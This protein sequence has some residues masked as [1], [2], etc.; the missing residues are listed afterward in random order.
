MRRHHVLVDPSERRSRL[1]S[2]AAELVADTGMVVHE[3]PDLVD[4]HVELVEMP[5]LLRGELDPRFLE[6]PPEVVVVTLRHHQKCL[7]LESGEPVEAGS[8]PALAPGFLAVIDREDDPEGLIRQG[9]E[10]VIGARLADARFFFEEDRKRRMA[11]LVPSLARLDHHRRLGSIGHKAERIGALAEGLARRLSL[12]LDPQT[13]RR[14]A[15]LVKADLL[16]NMV[17]ELPELQGVMGGHYLRLEGEPEA[18]WTAA[19][20]HYRP[21]GFDG[22]LPS[23]E[24]GRVLGVADRLDTVAGL[25]AAGE[26][27][28]GSK[29][30]FG[31]RRAA[32]G[33]VRI[34]AES[35]WELDL[36][37]ALDDAVRQV[38][39]LLSGDGGPDLAELRTSLSTFVAERVRRYLVELAGA[40]PDT[41]DAVMA[42]GWTRLPGLLA[43][44]R[45]LG[46]VRADERFRALALAFKRVRNIT[47]GQPEDIGTT[48]DESA[49]AEPAELEL[50]TAAQVLHERLAT[51]LEARSLDEAF[52][53]MGEIAEVLDR[54]FVDVLVMADDERVRGNRIA[55]LRS[56][57]RDFLTLAD[58]SKL[59]VEGGN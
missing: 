49:P 30:P 45:A 56:L 59:H 9:N 3:D 17:G 15:G 38:A 34:V 19:R 37:A 21:Q 53:A 26:L 28:T 33:A 11:D 13:I 5:G 48:I 27:P 50:R 23:S 20:D 7:V 25:F 55:L 16:T 14:A 57:G 8:Q 31:L 51:H 58:L 43:R 4:E 24:L 39:P 44:A 35:G 46:T 52:A 32:Q 2:L 12:G 47:E 41:A 10:W 42:A 54:F 36:E 29:D 40:L 18:V 22:E 1:E 6:L